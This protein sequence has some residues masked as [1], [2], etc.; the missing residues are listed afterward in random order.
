MRKLYSV[1][2]SE[3]DRQLN[4][5][6]TIAPTPNVNAAKS[7]K[8]FSVLECLKLKRIHIFESYRI[9]DTVHQ[10]IRTDMTVLTFSLSLTFLSCTANQN[11]CFFCG[12]VAVAAA[13]E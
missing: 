4:P 1:D 13:A 9:P 2:N 11:E 8:C 5:Q 3:R 12:D 10:K 6:V 7:S